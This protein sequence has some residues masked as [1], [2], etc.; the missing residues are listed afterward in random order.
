MKSSDYLIPGSVCLSFSRSIFLSSP[1]HGEDEIAA[2]GLGM[3][4]RGLPSRCILILFIPKSTE[5]RDLE[6]H[7]YI[8][9]RHPPTS[10]DRTSDTGEARKLLGYLRTYKCAQ[11]EKN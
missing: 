6:E 10:F 1:T 7:Y 5:V 9:S 11:E 2:S 8:L 4:S 3:D